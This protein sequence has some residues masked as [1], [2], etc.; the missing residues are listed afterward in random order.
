MQKALDLIEAGSLPH[1]HSHACVVVDETGVAEVEL[2]FFDYHRQAYI[3]ENGLSPR[4]FF[5]LARKR[6]L[7]D[8]RAGY[9]VGPEVTRFLRRDAR[10]GVASREGSLGDVRCK[11]RT[12]GEAKDGPLPVEFAVPRQDRSQGERPEI[13][14][15]PSSS[16][17]SEPIA[18]SIDAGAEARVETS[19]KSS[20]WRTPTAADVDD[21]P[22]VEPGKHTGTWGSILLAIGLLLLFAV[23]LAWPP[24][25]ARVTMTETAPAVGQEARPDVAAL[26]AAPVVLQPA[27]P[28]GGV[29]LASLGSRA[30]APLSAN[31]ECALRAKDVFKECENCPEMV[32]IPAG[33]FTMGSPQSEKE[34]QVFE[35]P[36]HQV[37]IGNAIAVGRFEVSFREWDVCAVEGGCGGHIPEDE[38]WGRGRRPVVNVSWN[39]AQAYAAWLSSKTGKTYRLLT[40]AEWEYAARGGTPTPFWWGSSISASQANYDGNSTYGGGRKGKYRGKTVP[41]GSFASNPFGLYDVHGNV[42]EWDREDC[43]Q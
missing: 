40:E 14:T 24:D 41:V 26:P 1:R 32:I 21:T 8:V 31:E 6:T 16:P 11:V 25:P 15:N 23:A 7:A 39:D 22:L 4:P 43:P 12:Y 9:V 18:A 2:S 19:C 3:G 13:S 29:T 28:C 38:G 42:A 5:F 36:Q 27:R 35:G 17:P 30:P 10:F 37:T 34:R 20:A 33:S